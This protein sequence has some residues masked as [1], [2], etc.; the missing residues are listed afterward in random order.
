MLKLCRCQ[1]HK[2]LS[3][4]LEDCDSELLRYLTKSHLASL[5]TALRAIHCEEGLMNQTLQLAGSSLVALMLSVLVFETK[6]DQ[7]IE[8]HSMSY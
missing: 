4:R 7:Q 3:N 1:S 2:G 6:I 5:F 8:P